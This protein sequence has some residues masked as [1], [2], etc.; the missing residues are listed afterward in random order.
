MN[1]LRWAALAAL[2]AA[3]AALPVG[4]EELPAILR[5][6]AERYY[7]PAGAGL[8][9]LE[10]VVR[11]PRYAKVLADAVVRVYWK[12]GRTA[13]R[14]ENYK[15]DLEPRIHELQRLLRDVARNVV[16]ETI[17]DLARR[18]QVTVK[19]EGELTHIL[20]APR[21]GNGDSLNHYWFDNELRIV[22]SVSEVVTQGKPKRT[23]FDKLEIQDKDGL[24]LVVGMKGASPTGSA[25]ILWEYEKVGGFWLPTKM[26]HVTGRES[27]TTVFL[28]YKVNQGLSDDLFRD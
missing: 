25:E 28:D 3:L 24:L 14:I 11:N 10:V 2:L 26:T 23:D 15:P 1:K 19:E 4:S 17:V 18:S 8:K 7:N 5:K 20:L 9:D 27:E 12:D 6:V 13:A 22:R 16:P 21:G